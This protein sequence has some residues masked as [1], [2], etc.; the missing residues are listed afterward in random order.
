MASSTTRRGGFSM[1]QTDLPNDPVELAKLGNL[2]ADED[3]RRSF[4]ADAEGTMEEWEIDRSGIPDPLVEAF[5]QL[6]EDQLG[7]ISFVNRRL[8]EAGF[9]GLLP[10]KW[11]V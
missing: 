1:D 5:Q 2:L 8:E 11:P 6:S 7:A 9:S 3:A 10:L 4:L